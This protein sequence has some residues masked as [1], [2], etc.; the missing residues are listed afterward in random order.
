MQSGYIRADYDRPELHWRTVSG[1]TDLFG[2][3]LIRLVETR[4]TPPAGR[5]DG[6]ATRPIAPLVRG[7]ELPHPPTANAAGTRASAASTLVSDLGI[8]D[9][10]CPGWM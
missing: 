8:R 7:D 1:D 5:P 9:F 3:G 4:A 2:D 10:L 6:L